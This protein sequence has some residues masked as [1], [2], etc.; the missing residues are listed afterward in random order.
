MDIAFDV[1]PIVAKML[2]QDPTAADDIRVLA[3]RLL[4]I[5]DSI[6]RQWKSDAFLAPSGMTDRVKMR[7][8]GPDGIVKQETDTGG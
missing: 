6:D 4:D 8:T 5:A 3:K 7:V 2:V 1:R